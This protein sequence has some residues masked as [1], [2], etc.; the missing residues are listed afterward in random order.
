MQGNAPSGCSE[1]ISRNADC[2]NKG[3]GIPTYHGL[4]EVGYE[5]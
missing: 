4:E 1:Q 3:M 2:I 5:H